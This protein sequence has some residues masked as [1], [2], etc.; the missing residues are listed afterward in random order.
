MARLHPN[1]NRTAYD[2]LGAQGEL[3]VLEILE[4]GLPDAYDIF[5]G[6]DWSTMYQGDQR[7]GD[8]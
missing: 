3:R 6:V 5:H 1:L 7:I 4:L 8:R 2:T